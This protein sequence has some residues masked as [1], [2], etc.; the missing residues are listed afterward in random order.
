MSN[1]FRAGKDS[2]RD[3]IIWLS[4]LDLAKRDYGGPVIFISGNVHDFADNEGNNLHSDLQSEIEKLGL[5]VKFFRS[6]NHFN[7]IHTNHISFIDE[8]WLSINLDWDFLNLSVL[9]GVRGIHCGYYFE[10]FH[11][12]ISRDDDGILNYDPLQ[13]VYDKSILMFNVGWAVEN[14]YNVWMRLGGEVL[15]AYLLDDKH[16]NFLMVQFHTEVSIEIKDKVIVSYE[17]NYYA[18]TSGLSTHEAYEVC[19]F[20]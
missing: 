9:E 7:E 2:F 13:A 3:A 19:K 12:T 11:K 20:S 14:Q 8:Q 1:L 5:D 10:T 16:A 6:L 17:A 4:V 18:E 15:V